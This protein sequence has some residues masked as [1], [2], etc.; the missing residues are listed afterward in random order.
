MRLTDHVTLNFN[1]DMSTATVFL[2]IEKAS[3]TTW[4]P[5]LLYKFPELHFSPSL[6]KLINSFLSHR[7]FAVMVEGELSTPPPPQNIQ[8]GVPQGFV[9]SPTLYSLYINDTP[10]I[11]GVY[12]P[13]F[14]NDTCLYSTDRKILNLTWKNLLKVW[15]ASQ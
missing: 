9:L 4:H 7:K 13:L 2:D 15:M 1:N 8:A 11:L 14:A 12:L 10:Q 3:D 5:G 6:M